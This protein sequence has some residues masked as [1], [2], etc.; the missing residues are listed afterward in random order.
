[1]TTDMPDDGPTLADALIQIEALGEMVA[2][3]S[4]RINDLTITP[5]AEPAPAH[6]PTAQEMTDD[7]GPVT[8]WAQRATADDWRDLIE[9]VE[10]LV[11][12]YELVQF[13]GKLVPC[14]PAH[15]G[16]VEELAALRAGWIAAQRL[17]RKADTDAVAVW[18]D[19]ALHPFINRF[20]AYQLNL[21]TQGKHKIQ[22]DPVPTDLEHVVV[23]TTG[24][25]GI[26]R[27]AGQDGRP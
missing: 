15:G 19:R 25:V 12:T 8:S 1:M 6:L 27:R 11:D 18:H 24:E 3:L 13:T 22:R 2:V 5:P 26:D 14:W 7:E 17:A 20:N 23:L 4:E 9:W 16:I 10:W 21:C